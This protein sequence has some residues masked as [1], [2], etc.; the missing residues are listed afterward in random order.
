MLNSYEFS[1]YTI[2]G[3]AKEALRPWSPYLIF[4]RQLCKR[5]YYDWVDMW[6]HHRN[7]NSVFDY[8][9]VILPPFR[10]VF[11]YFWLKQSG[12]LVVQQ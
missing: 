6:R 8:L 4:I 10:T 1:N 12:N 11:D 5:S 3:V 2:M 9:S 7:A